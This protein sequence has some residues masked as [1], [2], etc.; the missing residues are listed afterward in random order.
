MA[1]VDPGQSV[2]PVDPGQSGQSVKPVDPG[3]SG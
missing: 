2:K 1:D 3:Q